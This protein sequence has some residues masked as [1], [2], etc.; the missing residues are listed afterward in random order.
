LTGW[1]HNQLH[2]LHNHGVCVVH[3]AVSILYPFD[4]G[5]CTILS[6]RSTTLLELLCNHNASRRNTPLCRLPDHRHVKLCLLIVRGQPCE[7]QLSNSTTFIV[8]MAV[9]P[10]TLI[11]NAEEVVVGSTVKKRKRAFGRSRSTVSKSWLRIGCFG[12]SRKSCFMSAEP[13]GFGTS[14]FLDPRPPHWSHQ[15][16]PLS[17]L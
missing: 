7:M 9:T 1:Q 11:H 10:R 16:A 14:P 13:N 15:P 8:M 2:V 17:T 6:L 5:S 3:L 12:S 4:T